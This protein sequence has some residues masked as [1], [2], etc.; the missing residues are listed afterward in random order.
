MI[1]IRRN[2]SKIEQRTAITTLADLHQFLAGCDLSGTELAQLR[3]AVKRAGELMGQGTLDVAANQRAVFERLQTISPAMADMSAA[4]YANMKSRV[5]KAFRLAKPQLHN[6]RSRY[7]LKGAWKELQS[8]LTVKL[9]RSTSRLF[10]FAASKGWEPVDVS[11]EVITKFE[12]YLRD[13]AMIEDWKGT[14]RQSIKAWNILASTH[15]DLSPLTPPACK[16]TSYWVPE[17]EW[18]PSLSKEVF[19]LLE[20]LGSPTDFVDRTHKPLKPATVIQ[21]RHTVTTV[22]SALVKS[23]YEL[24]SLDS[25]WAVFTPWNIERV[26]QFLFE[27]SGGSVTDQMFQVAMRALTIAKFKGKPAA[28]IE[29]FRRMMSNVRDRTDR[30]RGLTQKNRS[31]LDRLDDQRFKDQLLLLPYTL[32]ALAEKRRTSAL[33]PAIARTAMAIELL[34]VCSMR[35]TNLTRLELGRSIRT[36][37]D[38]KQPSW[39]IEIDADE[40]KNAQP[41]RFPLGE[42]TTQMLTIYLEQWRP[43]LSIEPNS[44]LF[45]AGD[46]SCLDA[47]TMAYAIGSWSK[48][49]L[50]ISITPHQ[51]RH[52]SADMYLRTH[53]DALYTVSQHLGHR[54]VNTTKNFYTAPKQR[55]ASKRFQEHVLEVRKVAG[56]KIKKHVKGKSTP[57]PGSLVV[58]EDQL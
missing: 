20:W 44:W 1:K 22:I 55:E 15:E 50:G 11:D 47:K 25:L 52:L 30:T 4:S 9:Q 13:E 35:R 49:I 46:G 37:G 39:I 26:L 14:L 3:S 6:P 54:D 18:P 31:L 8:G 33:A 17:C 12:T 57:V 45:P 51:F 43:S 41:L 36:I 24:S 38:G 29:T 28:D 32:F 7:P 21:Y 2:K 23:G 56:I 58:W 53:P 19:E 42:Q 5:R 40:V 27:R 16:R 10:H 34:L 48:R